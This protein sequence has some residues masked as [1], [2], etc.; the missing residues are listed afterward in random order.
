MTPERGKEVLYL[1][2]AEVAA[3]GLTPVD[4]LELVRTAL[5]EHGNKRAEMPAKIGIHPLPDTLMIG[6]GGRIAPPPLPHHRTYG[7]VYGGSIGY[8]TVLRLTSEVRAR[9]EKSSTGPAS[10]LG[11]G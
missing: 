11:S 4:V 10:E 6:I 7:S 8:A 9:P 5:T 3:A 2:Q 1:T